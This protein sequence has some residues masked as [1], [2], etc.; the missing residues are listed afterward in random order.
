MPQIMTLKTCPQS[1]GLTSILAWLLNSL[2]AIITD[3]KAS[4]RA[5]ALF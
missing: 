1:A 2:Y 5:T 4:A 3:K